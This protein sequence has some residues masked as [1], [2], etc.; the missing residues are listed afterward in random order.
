[1]LMEGS[2]KK[3]LDDI[4]VA[5]RRADRVM[6][7]EGPLADGRVRRR[8]IDKTQYGEL[9]PVR[10]PLF[11]LVFWVGVCLVVCAWVF[12]FFLRGRCVALVFSHKISPLFPVCCGTYILFIPSP[13]LL[14][15][16]LLLLLT[17]FCSSCCLL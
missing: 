16:L 9:L 3:Q 15:L 14:L 13:L 10:A 17:C 6:V 5:F 8:G 7:E 12:C 4:L 11:W 1:M 2:Y